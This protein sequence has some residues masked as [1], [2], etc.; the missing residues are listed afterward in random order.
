MGV[1][2]IGRGQ[3]RTNAHTLLS[4]PQK[5]CPC[6]SC[7]RVVIMTSRLRPSSFQIGEGSVRREKDV[8][9]SSMPQTLASARICAQCADAD[10][11]S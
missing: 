9:G 6:N 2:P 7:H 4:L 8:D 1:M 5:P 3:L 11:D 10:A